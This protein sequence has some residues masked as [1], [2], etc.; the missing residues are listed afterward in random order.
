MTG[1][2][3]LAEVHLPSEAKHKHVAVIE[4]PIDVT[5]RLDGAMIF[6]L[7]AVAFGVE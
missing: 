2:I 3:L 6:Y 1:M 5:V 4:G 7:F